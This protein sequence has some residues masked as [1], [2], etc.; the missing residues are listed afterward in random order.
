MA[1]G[2]SLK[3]DAFY[4]S[5]N[6]VEASKNFSKTLPL[7]DRNVTCGAMK[8]KLKVEVTAKGSI[9]GHIGFVATGK[10]GKGRCLSASSS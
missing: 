2:G 5:E 7:I 8:G 1:L 9:K 10:L 3:N 4:A 6:S